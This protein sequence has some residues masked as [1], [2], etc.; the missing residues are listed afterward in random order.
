MATATLTRGGRLIGIT[1][2][3][4][5]KSNKTNNTNVKTPA[6]ITVRRNQRSFSMTFAYL[7]V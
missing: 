4:F 5:T 2:P 6:L 3:Y 7:G 1:R